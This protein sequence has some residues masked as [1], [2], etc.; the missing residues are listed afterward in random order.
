V[1]TAL[2]LLT[3]NPPAPLSQQQMAWPVIAIICREITMSALREWAAA[4][5]GAAHKVGARSA[6]PARTGRGAPRRQRGRERAGGRARARVQ[7]HSCATKAPAAPPHH[8]PCPRDRRS[9]ARPPARPAP[10]A[11]KVNSLGK[12][13]T[14]LQMMAMAALMLQRQHMGLIGEVCAAPRAAGGAGAP[15]AAAGR[16]RRSC[17]R[18][19]PELPSCR[20]RWAGLGAASAMGAAGAMAGPKAGGSRAG[21]AGASPP[22]RQR[23]ATPGAAHNGA[24]LTRPPARAAAPA[25]EHLLEDSVYA[26]WLLLWGA[27]LLGLWSLAIYMSNVW[28]HFLHP[29]QVKQH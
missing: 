24:L 22:G 10:Q 11:V 16:C 9:P 14:A 1:C 23:P 27:A 20:R 8:S 3:I 17:R 21:C 6:L 25:A 2:I 18:A 29:P 5:G 28:V 7:P 26:A 4:S 13:K 15:L 12:W 19:A